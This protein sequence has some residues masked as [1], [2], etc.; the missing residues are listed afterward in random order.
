MGREDVAAFRASLAQVAER[1]YALDTDPQLTVLRSG[2]LQGRSAALAATVAPKVDGLWGRYLAVKERS[3]QLADD[4]MVDPRDAAEVASLLADLSAIDAVA[5][6]L[7]EA[8]RRLLPWVDQAAGTRAATA[9][10]AAQLRIDPDETVLALAR[11]EVAALQEDVAS[12]P[13]SADG[14]AAHEAVTAAVAWVEERSRGRQGLPAAL[15]R[16]AAT[17]ARL[18]SAIGEG[19][20]AL[21]AARARVVVA[22]GAGLLEPLSPAVVDGDERSL[23]PWLER[24]RDEAVEGDADAVVSG[25]GRWQVVADGAL[26]NAE[27]VVV[28]NRGPVEQRDRLRGLLDAY[29]AKAGAAQRAEHP[30]VADLVR[31]ARAALFARPADL[32]AGEAAVRALGAALSTTRPLRTSPPHPGANS[33]MNGEGVQP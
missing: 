24:L 10:S 31:A 6:Q 26:A 19:R 25:L 29:E 12:D 28:A 23:G 17:L 30:E 27:A 21:E 20:E 22:E 32:A 5:G 8:W 1:L 4:G 3:D 2:T 7:A 18:R 11:R 13:L 14:N 33:E 9:A 15:D 16:A